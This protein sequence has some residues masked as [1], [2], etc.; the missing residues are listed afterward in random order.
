MVDRL[1]FV[2]GTSGATGHQALALRRADRGDAE[3]GL[4][5]EAA[6]ATRDIP[7]CR[8][9]HMISGL[10]GHTRADFANDTGTL[11]AED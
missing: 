5:A 9:D 6:L 7:A 10:D 1:T 11:M 2:V 4:A 8:G 3:V